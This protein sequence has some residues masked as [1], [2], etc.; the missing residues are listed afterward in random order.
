MAKLISNDVKAGRVVLGRVSGEKFSA[1]AGLRASARTS[2]LQR[3]S[4]AA[5]ES[6]AARRD[7][8]R[9]EFRK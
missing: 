9:R 1:V 2:R 3:E 8:I 5:G 4:D 7:R 6:S